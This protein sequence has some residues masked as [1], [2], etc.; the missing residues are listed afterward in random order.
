LARHNSDWRG[1]KDN[2]EEYYNR[3]AERE[4][5][6]LVK[7]AYHAVE[8]GVTLHYLRKHLPPSG[9]LLDIGGGSG[10]YC[11]EL[12]RRG[13]RMTLADVSPRLLSM[14]EEEFRR[15]AVSSRIARVD[16]A[17]CRDLSIYGNGQ[18]D[19]V[20]AL[21]PIYH[22]IDPADRDMA[23]SEIARVSRAGA[24]VF[25]S[26]ISRYGL[27]RTLLT[28][29]EF[30]YEFTD[31]RHVEEMIRGGVHR[32]SWHD[33]EDVFP[34]A[35]FCT[36]PEL[37]GLAEPHGFETLEIAA[38]EG[39]SSHHREATE[40]L[41]KNERAWQLWWDIILETSNEPSLVGASEH[42]LYVGRKT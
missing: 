14:A 40:R 10:R 34:D 11:V 29:P 1:S 24:T 20:L 28:H 41:R 22:L 32:A 27:Y 6:R 16:R 15:E 21:G 17:D 25:L 7:D 30:E 12:A 18:F 13:Y 8:F 5:G 42:I 37:A 39:L 35:W 3:H 4:H 31:K 9:H 38:C 36:P 19:G 2:V 26:G 33:E 23:I